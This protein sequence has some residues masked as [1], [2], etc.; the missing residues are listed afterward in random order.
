MTASP[1]QLV[2]D[3]AHRQALGA[4]DFLVSRSNDAAVEMIDR[5]PNWPHPAS[6]VSGPQG[7]GKSH[8]ANVWRLRSGAGLV[9]AADLDDDTVAA[10]ADGAA[11]V[12]ED[13]D[14]GIADE[15]ALFHL[16]NRA[17]ESKLSL[18]LTSR[19]PPGEQEFRIPDL[20]SRL[21][22]LPVVEVEPPDE[23]LLKAVLVKLFDDRQLSVEPQV[24]DYLSVRMERSMAAASRVVAAVDRQALA[25]HR[26]VTRPL[27]AQALAGLGE[28][29]E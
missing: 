4:E 13:L 7:S 12:V 21:R 20:R 2:F 24:I 25:T 5:W 10:L 17:R 15:K 16:L 9:L 26:K 8:L 1:R 22:A 27:A 28:S 11:L 23:A 6:L 14:R 29:R 19:T 3:L 18:L